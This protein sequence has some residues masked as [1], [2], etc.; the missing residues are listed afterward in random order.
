MIRHIDAQSCTGCGQCFKSC[1][2]DVFRLNTR[3]PEVSPCMA[4][5]PAGTDIRTYNHL[6]QQ[7]RLEEA[8]EVLKRGT[9]FPAL[10]GRVCF[11]PCESQ[12]TRASMDESVN[13]NALEQFLGDLDLQELP[14]RPAVRHLSR[15]AVVGSGPAGL[16][17]A[18][19]LALEGWPVTVFEALPRPGGMLRY[20]IPAYRLPDDVIDAHIRKLEALGV[21]FRCNVRIGEGKDLSLA[22]LR[23]LGFRA[24]L[25]APGLS[26][27]KTLPLEGMNLNGV[28]TGVE[29]LR[30]LRSG[31]IP[32]AGRRV[33]VVG[34]GNVAIDAAISAK[35]LGAEE[36]FMCCLEDREHMPAF[37]HNI[38]DALER[39]VV[40]HPSLGPAR[41][42]GVDGH[43]RAAKFKYC[44][45]L[46]DEQGRFAPTFDES[47]TVR[48][49]ADQVIFAIGQTG[50]FADIASGVDMRGPRILVSGSS[51]RTSRENVFA[52]GDA[53]SGPASVIQAIVGG[54]DAARAMARALN[55]LL[56]EDKAPVERPT[57]KAMPIDKLP[58]LPRNERRTNPEGGLFDEAV[59]GFDQLDAQAEAMR[60]LT[61]GSKASIRYGDDCMTC[62]SCELHCPADAIDVHPFKERLPYTLY[63]DE[64]G[65]I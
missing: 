39:G 3:Q 8:L 17:A 22:D 57:A 5:C 4:A 16:A 1:S 62:F 38:K 65:R 64:G 52:A 37:E 60:C 36:V 49:E 14:E 61:C 29:F 12:C 46:F 50:D 28:F 20:G 59:A 48:L 42:E 33:C 26:V 25:L 40:L 63:D 10:T 19:Y 11:H 7:N 2:L 34:G 23:D 24:A 55:G 58:H 47:K 43:V 6:L 30:S 56:V 53:V 32:P 51:M 45:S 27:G 9:P 21:E 41:I 15:A 44:L 13:I 54:R 31:D 18:W 35:M